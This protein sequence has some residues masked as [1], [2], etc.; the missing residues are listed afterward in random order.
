M[1]DEPTPNRGQ[2]NLFELP[3]CE[4]GKDR[5][6]G[7]KMKE[8]SSKSKVAIKVRA[9][10]KACLLFAEPQGGNEDLLLVIL[11]FEL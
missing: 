7:L 9:K 10:R 11:N 6:A 1:K 4:G 2:S 3:R 5:E 8:Q